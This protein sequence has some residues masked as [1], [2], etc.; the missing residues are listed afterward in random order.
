[1]N[2]MELNEQDRYSTPVLDL[3]QLLGAQELG[4][5]LQLW[6]EDPGSMSEEK[7]ARVKELGDLFTVDLVTALYQFQVAQREREAAFTARAMAEVKDLVA[8]GHGF[9]AAPIGHMPGANPPRNVGEFFTG[10]RLP[11]RKPQQVPSF[12]GVPSESRQDS[13]PMDADRVIDELT[14]LRIK[15]QGTFLSDVEI[16]RLKELE[17]IVEEDA[18]WQHAPDSEPTEPSLIT[19]HPEYNPGSLVEV[20]HDVVNSVTETGHIPVAEK[21]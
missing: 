5:L 19:H 21:S 9:F 7:L 4:N 20:P 6:A 2:G 18:A 10:E 16:E 8:S 11:R 14:A 15:A 17:A 1:M 12:P 13:G 3:R